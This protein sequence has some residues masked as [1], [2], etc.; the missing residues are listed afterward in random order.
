MAELWAALVDPA[1]VGVTVYMPGSYPYVNGFHAPGPSGTAGF[2]TNYFRAV[3]PFAIPPG[4]VR[5][6]EVFVIAGHHEAARGTVYRLRPEIA[7]LDVL[8]P[9]GWLDEPEDGSVHAG[10]IPVAGWAWDNVGISR[11]DVLVDDV[12]VAVA[13]YGIDRPDVA[14][15]YPGAPV[16]TG[17]GYLLDG[18]AL[19]NGPHR[20]MTR[21]WDAAGNVLELSAT[22]VVNN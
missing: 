8:A 5:D 2:G 10:S 22:V 19:S 1:G 15:A 6:L 7:V 21:S 3:T 16:A 13:T 12:F 17:Y 14:A 20:V 9:L 4:A 11:V 18:A